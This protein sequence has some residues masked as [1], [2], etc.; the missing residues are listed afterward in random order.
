MGESRSPILSPGSMEPTLHVSECMVV[1]GAVPFGLG[2]TCHIQMLVFTA[3]FN[4]KIT[5]QWATHLE[6]APASQSAALTRRPEGEQAWCC[7]EAVSG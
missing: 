4:L 6:H 2:G 5:N 1:V 3:G 7:H